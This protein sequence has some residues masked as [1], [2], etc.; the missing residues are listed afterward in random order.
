MAENIEIPVNADKILF[1]EDLVKHMM[2]R[3]ASD[4]D[5][6][7]S[8]LEQFRGTVC[9][10]FDGDTQAA[11]YYLDNEMEAKLDEV[12]QSM[13]RENNVNRDGYVRYATE[14]ANYYLGEA[15]DAENL[16]QYCVELAVVA[17]FFYH[18]TT[19]GEIAV[20]EAPSLAV[21]Y[22]VNALEGFDVSA[23]EWETLKEAVKMYADI[24]EVKRKEWEPDSSDSDQ[25]N[26]ENT[27][28][29]NGLPNQSN[30][31]DGGNDV[32]NNY[33][34]SG[35]NRLAVSGETK[36][37][38]RRHRPY[39]ARCMSNKARRRLAE[40]E[41]KTSG[42]LQES[43]ST[44]PLDF[45][46]KILIGASSSSQAFGPGSSNVDQASILPQPSNLD[47]INILPESS[48]LDQKSIQPKSCETV[49]K[50]EKSPTDED[51]QNNRNISQLESGN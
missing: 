1:A 15:F 23:R 51:T 49:Q 11:L 2:F 41:C 4:N 27:S 13:R 45:E 8:S 34:N 22:I 20:L 42:E 10:H 38:N 24:A 5:Y 19:E 32:N 21:S 44:L 14:R 46:G 28:A 29:S 39:P 35:Q 47:Q 17:V 36:L 43:L 26:V 18:P 9:N 25:E 48:S 31:G 3:V 30:I 16:L 33:F 40:K 50:L 37:Q 6:P 12:C 7:Q